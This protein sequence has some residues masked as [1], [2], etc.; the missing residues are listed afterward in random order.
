MSENISRQQRRAQERNNEKFSRKLNTTQM[1]DGFKGRELRG[2][3]TGALNALPVDSSPD[4]KAAEVN[5]MKIMLARGDNSSVSDYAN[6]I[7]KIPDTVLF[8]FTE[9]QLHQYIVGKIVEI[10]RAN[11]QLTGIPTI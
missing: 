10:G 4:R 11:R 6:I 7:A 1:P 3:I 8:S 5:A 2:I 9:L